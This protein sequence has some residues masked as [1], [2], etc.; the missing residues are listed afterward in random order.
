MGEKYPEFRCKYCLKFKRDP[1][2][3]VLKWLEEHHLPRVHGCIWDRECLY[4]GGPWRITFM[5]GNHSLMID[6]PSYRRRWGV[7]EGRV[8]DRGQLLW[9]FN[10]PGV[11]YEEIFRL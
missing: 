9:S 11:R 7:D 5:W 10:I 6:F 8:F 1:A 2:L 4:H 3:K